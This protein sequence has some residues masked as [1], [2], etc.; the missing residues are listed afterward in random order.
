[1][2]FFSLLLW[3]GIKRSLDAKTY[4]VSLSLAFSCNCYFIYFVDFIICMEPFHSLFV[5]QVHILYNWEFIRLFTFCHSFT[6]SSREEFS[7]QIATFNA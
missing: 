4:I 3:G 7:T 5:I 2:L 6:P 1:M